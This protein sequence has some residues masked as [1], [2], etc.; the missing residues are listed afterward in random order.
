MTNFTFNSRASYLEFVA[1]W[2]AE[3][4]ANSVNQRTLKRAIS[5]GM[6]A[7]DYVYKEQSQLLGGVIKVNELL[8]SRAA[9][10]VEAARQWAA[11]HAAP[12]VV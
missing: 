12:E 8:E 5:A 1:T 4:A 11:E 6:R 2:K 3:Y 9:G 7:D 10:K